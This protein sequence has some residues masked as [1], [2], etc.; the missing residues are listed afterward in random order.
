[1]S[2][3]DRR[4]YRVVGVD[5]TSALL[6]AGRRRYGSLP[7]VRADF[8]HIPFHA[9]SFDGLW[10][11]ASLMHLPKQDARCIL[12]DLCRLVRP[13]GLF[14]A[15]VS[16]GVKS[17]LVTD[18]G[19]IGRRGS[20]SRHRSPSRQTGRLGGQACTNRPGYSVRPV[21]ESASVKRQPK[22]HRTTSR[23]RGCGESRRGLAA[24]NHIGVVQ[25]QATRSFDPH[26]QR[27]THADRDRS[28]PALLHSRDPTGSP[29]QGG[30][31]AIRSTTAVVDAVAYPSRRCTPSPN[32]RMRRSSARQVELCYRETS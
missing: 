22:G 13:G 23:E 25:L 27:D 32:V 14:A 5:R 2:D 18:G 7:L 4:G 19:A 20:S 30:A 9:M 1:M 29:R 26:P 24:M 31:G 10:V 3:L 6:A 15:T 16:Y 28:H 12:A 17:R 8:R 21:S 11:A